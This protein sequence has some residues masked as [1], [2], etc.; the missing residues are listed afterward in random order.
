VGVLCGAMSMSGRRGGRALAS[1]WRSVSS[2]RMR[3]FVRRAVRAVRIVIRNDRIPRLIRWGGA[4]GLLP[5]PGPFDEIVLLL[6]G[7]V[8]WV[9]YREQLREAWDRAA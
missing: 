8:L 4:A 7:A 3:G 9:F 5:V 6:V 1:R 2:D